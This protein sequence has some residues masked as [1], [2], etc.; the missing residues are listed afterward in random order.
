MKIR[1]LS[2]MDILKIKLRQTPNYKTT[3]EDRITINLACYWHLK[4]LGMHEGASNQVNGI[5]RAITGQE[6]V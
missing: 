6:V 5:L 1:K 2:K 3:T 4:D